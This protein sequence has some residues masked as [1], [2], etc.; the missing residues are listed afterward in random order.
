M[1]K[2]KF[3]RDE[4]LKTLQSIFDLEVAGDVIRLTKLL[5]VRDDK[6]ISEITTLTQVK[7]NY[8]TKKHRK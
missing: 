4:F 1:P 2:S 5:R 8:E 6:H 3:F 7:K